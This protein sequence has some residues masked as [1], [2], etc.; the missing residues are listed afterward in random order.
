MKIDVFF[1]PFIFAFDQVG[2]LHFFLKC[3]LLLGGLWWKLPSV[4]LVVSHSSDHCDPFD[5]VSCRY[6]SAITTYCFVAPSRAHAGWRTNTALQWEMT[7]WEEKQ[8][9]TPRRTWRPPL[10][11]LAL[12]TPFRWEQVDCQRRRA[13]KNCFSWIQLY[14]FIASCNCFSEK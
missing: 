12:L 4:W 14:A 2:E 9:K 8:R 5:A 1:F 3:W 7:R 10:A 13:T 6:S 11:L